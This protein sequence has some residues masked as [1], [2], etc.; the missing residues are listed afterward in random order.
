MTR[1]NEYIFHKDFIEFKFYNLF[2]S[3]LHRQN[4]ITRARINAVDF[5]TYP[6][7]LIIDNQE[8]VFFNHNDEDGLKKFVTD[9]KIPS[10]THIDTWAI[11][12]RDYLDTKLDGKEV[13]EGNMKLE[14][15]GIDMQMFEKI[16][17]Q[18]SATL[19]M[20][21]EWSYLGL[22]DLLAMKQYRNPFY[23]F[24]GRKYYWKV[25]EVALKGSEYVH[26]K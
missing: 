6:C 7:S 26:R 19:I 3:S 16:S 14:S 8:V 2:F 4:K 18:I 13:Q 5:N 11:L 24:Y 10:S 17:K 20:T 12:T 25:M 23:R 15:V 9:N 21:M 1:P 22:W